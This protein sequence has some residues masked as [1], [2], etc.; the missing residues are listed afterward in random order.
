MARA[1]ILMRE[2]R[3]EARNGR[4]RF[5]DWNIVNTSNGACWEPVYFGG[6]TSGEAISFDDAIN[7]IDKVGT[8][9]DFRNPYH[10]DSDSN[11]ALIGGAVILGRSF[12]FDNN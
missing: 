1:A 11:I 10:R 2:V 5:F 8:G 3:M 6:N 9:I 12:A 7:R 4:F